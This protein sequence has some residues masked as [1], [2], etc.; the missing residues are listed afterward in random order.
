MTVKLTDELTECECLTSSLIMTSL[1]VTG[2]AAPADLE[3]LMPLI[4]GYQAFNLIT[5][6][7]DR[8]TRAFFGGVIASPSESFII[9]ARVDGRIVGFATGYITRS[10]YLAKRLVHLGDLFVDPPERR[11]GIGRAL[12]HAVSTHAAALGLDTVRWLTSPTHLEAH[13]LYDSLGA[14]PSEHRLYVLQ[15]GI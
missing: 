8:Q 1:S 6:V 12:I 13:R 2:L 7:D 10:G 15:R 14:V 5:T 11:R 3:E 9:V 4:R